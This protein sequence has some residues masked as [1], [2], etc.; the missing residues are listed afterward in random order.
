M[1]LHNPVSDRLEFE[2][3]GKGHYATGPITI[4][5]HDTAPSGRPRGRKE[6]FGS[7]RHLRQGTADVARKITHGRRCGNPARGTEDESQQRRR[8]DGTQYVA[9]RGERVVIEPNED[10]IDG[11]VGEC[12]EQLVDRRPDCAAAPNS[13][14]Q[15]G[16]GAMHESK[17]SVLHGC[18]HVESV[19]TESQSHAT[20]IGER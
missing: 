8:V 6:P 15:S 10:G 9:N 2:T 12:G 18:I 16:L 20:C 13:P 14:Q 19:G 1:L 17:G 7:V 3:V 4:G 5:E 11:N